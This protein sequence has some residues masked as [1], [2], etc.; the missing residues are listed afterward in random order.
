VI[1]VLVALKRVASG[2]EPLTE[3]THQ[4]ARY[5]MLR[6]DMSSQNQVYKPVEPSSK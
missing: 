6:L 5:Q 4:S 1:A 3:G 2:T